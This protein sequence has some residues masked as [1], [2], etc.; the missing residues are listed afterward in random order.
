RDGTVTATVTISNVGETAGKEAVQ[1]YV[2]APQGGLVKPVRELKS[3]AKTRLLQPGESQTLSFRLTS[4][5]LASFNE[6]DSSWETA[7]GEYT[8]SFAASSR[9]IRCS[10][11]FKMK[12]AQAWKTS[13]HA[14]APEK[15]MDSSPAVLE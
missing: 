14:C 10:K 3:F 15:A 13:L 8:L 4:Y 11:S 1:V 5:D 2:S 7:A 6:A 12:N 9:D